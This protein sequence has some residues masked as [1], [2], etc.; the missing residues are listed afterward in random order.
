MNIT[1]FSRAHD[2]SIYVNQIG[3]NQQIL[4]TFEKLKPAKMWDFFQ[5]QMIKIKILQS[6][7]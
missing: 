2:I 3:R 5:V 6:P 7:D 1:F 4:L